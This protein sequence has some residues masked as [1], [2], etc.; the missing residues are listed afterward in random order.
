MV[1]LTIV[2]VSKPGLS[3]LGSGFVPLPFH[4]WKNGWVLGHGHSLTADRGVDRANPNHP[5][6][7]PYCSPTK[8]IMRQHSSRICSKDSR[9]Y[10]IP[11]SR[12]ESTAC[13]LAIIGLCACSMRNTLPI[14]R[15]DTVDRIV[16][17][18]PYDIEHRRPD[19]G[20]ATEALGRIFLQQSVE[21]LGT[22]G[23][24]RLLVNLF[25]PLT[26]LTVLSDL[27]IPTSY[28]WPRSA[29]N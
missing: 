14:L 23:T 3:N 21:D 9:L 27:E 22:L 20:I 5:V 19:V 15:Q 10:P 2:N 1:V 29:E 11:R 8:G 4:S 25:R 17:A 18:H 7:S 13:A 12:E 26:V 24:H 28:D 16:V 6:T